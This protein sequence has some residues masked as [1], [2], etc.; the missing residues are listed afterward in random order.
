MSPPVPFKAPKRRPTQRSHLERLVAAYARDN[1][2]PQARVRHLISSLALIGAL[3]RV[4]DASSGPRF[5]I[6]GGVAME[7]RLGIQ[8]RATN[9][10]DV[11]FRGPLSELLDTLDE[12][13]AEPYG[14]FEFS[15]YGELDEIRD[16]STQRQV[17]KIAFNG[18]GWQTLT[19]EAA[20]PEGSGGGD[21][22]I[23]LSAISVSQFGLDS[24]RL[25]AVM[26]I[27]YQIA[28]KL[29]AVTERPPNRENTRYWDLVDLLLLRD[30]VPDLGSVREACI[31]V[32]ENRETHNWPPE[33]VIPDPWHELYAAEATKL[34]FTPAD[35][36]E[37]AVE[38]RAF[39]AEIDAAKGSAIHAL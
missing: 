11:V 8:A 30:L 4:E 9:D 2:V 28:Q 34:K 20:R 16:T 1:D 21:P 13:F 32:F 22:E 18:R 24:P 29:H 23:V 10:F 12:A 6:K 26:A 37:A 19:I 27:R 39:I 17:V 36:H 14:G 31:D 25:I 38:L 33:L 3:Q 7:L 5:L 35:V 15:R